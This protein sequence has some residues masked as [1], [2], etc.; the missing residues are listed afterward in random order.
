MRMLACEMCNHEH[1]GTR[2]RTDPRYNRVARILEECP[3]TRLGRIKLCHVCQRQIYFNGGYIN[4]LA[5]VTYRMARLERDRRK[6]ANRR[7]SQ[8]S[9]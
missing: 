3:H 8:T 1:D 7:A 6:A 9:A 2:M 5:R 4:Y